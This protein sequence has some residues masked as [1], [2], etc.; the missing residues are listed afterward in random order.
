MK[1]NQF[2]NN[3]N[4]NQLEENSNLPSHPHHEEEEEESDD[5]GISN[6]SL[7]NHGKELILRVGD[8][9]IIFIKW[10]HEKPRKMKFEFD[11]FK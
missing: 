10:N 4:N 6:I 5:R 1:M 2:N 11:P 9:F 7:K 8:T 3:H